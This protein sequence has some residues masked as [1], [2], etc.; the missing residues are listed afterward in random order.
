MVKIKKNMKKTKGYGAKDYLISALEHLTEKQK[1]ILLSFIIGVVAAVI[2]FLFETTVNAIKNQVFNIHALGGTN[3]VLLVSPV[4]GIIIVTLYV[5]YLVKDNISHGVTKVLSAISQKASKMKSHNCYSSMIAGALTIGFGGSVGPEAPTVMTGSAVGSNFAKFFGLNHR[6]TTIL[7]GCGAAAAL[8]AIFKAPITGV[9]FVLEVLLI[10]MA[11]S[12]IIPLL[13]AAVTSTLFIYMIHGSEPVFDTA[14]KLSSITIDQTPFYIILGVMCGFVSFN[15]IYISGKIEGQFKRIKKQYVRWIIG[16]SVIGILV[17]LLPPLYGQGYDSITNLLA[18]DTDA[19]FKNSLFTNYQDNN[20]VIIG[21]LAAIILTKS[22]AMACTNAAGGVGGAFA[23]SIFLGAF[24][25]FFT[26][27]V[28]NTVFGMDLPIVCFTLVGMA[29]VMSGAMDSP[30]TAIF[31]IAEITGGY[32]LFVPLMLVSAISF[33]ISYYFNPYSVY[34]REFV[35]K[36]DKVTLNKDR[37]MLY[38]DINRLIESDFTTVHRD[39]TLGDMIDVV[40]HCKRNIFPVV[41][42]SRRLI[43]VITLDDIRRDIFDKELLVKNKVSDYMS[44]PPAIVLD[45]EPIAHILNKFDRTGT[46]NLPIVSHVDKKYIGF[47][48]KSKIFSEYRTE[49]QHE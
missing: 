31:L 22:V 17:L 25:G 4:V 10:E 36:G 27:Y 20:L 8:A 34:T 24:T 35:L 3:L 5:K 49:L 7:L 40:A 43:G 6:Q 1:L 28:L 42:E 47:I 13:I 46:W 32:K 21:F 41:N 45:D 39:M 19:L 16:G 44:I 26:A 29:G 9:V 48:S 18:G 23:P 37:T 15:I 33:A 12:S 14:I 38:I 30:L 2:V 11:I